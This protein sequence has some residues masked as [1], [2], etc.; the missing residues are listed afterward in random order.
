NDLARVNF[1]NPLN[2]DQLTLLEAV[3]YHHIAALFDPG[4]YAPLLNLLCIVDQH[5]IVASLIEQHGGLR[6]HKRLMGCSPLPHHSND[7][8]RNQYS[9]RIRQLRP[10]YYSVGIAL[11]LNVEQVAETGVRI[12]G[13][14]GQ[15]DM[16]GHMRA[17]V[18]R[19]GDP[20]LVRDDVGLARLKRDIDGVLAHDRRQR[21]G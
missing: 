17:L 2:N 1:L 11:Y 3:A 10:N 20:M 4:R 5:D 6:N 19:C 8:T 7:T 12:G 15:I 18:A 13:A 9:L 16:N 14:I 21:S